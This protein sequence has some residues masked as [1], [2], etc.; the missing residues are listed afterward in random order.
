MYGRLRDFLK[1]Y[2]KGLYKVR[3]IEYFLFPERPSIFVD[4]SASAS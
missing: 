4:F 2:I 3:D 1:K